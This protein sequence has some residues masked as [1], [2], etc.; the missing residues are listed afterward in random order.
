MERNE[1]FARVDLIWGGKN[2]HVYYMVY[3]N[4]DWTA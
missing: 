3:T 2:N 4:K 1:L